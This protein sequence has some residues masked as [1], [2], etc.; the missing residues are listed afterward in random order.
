MINFFKSKDFYLISVLYFIANILFLSNYDG[1]YWDDWI[2]YNQDQ[3]T[4]KILFA[5]IQHGI[6]GDFFLYLNHLGNGIF[7]FR[8]FTFLANF[9]M[10]ILVYLILSN[11]RELDRQSIFFIT[12]L[13][14]VAPLNSAKTS[15]AVA[16]FLFP[17]LL[18]YF[19]FYL[20]TVY[21]KHRYLLLRLLILALFLASCSTNS[22]LVFYFSI[23]FYLYYNQFGTDSTNIYAKIK[24]LGKHYWDFILIP[25]VY[26]IY[27]SLYLK[28]YGLY[29]GYNGISL[30]HLPKAFVIFF[31]NFDNSFIEVIA[32]SVIT[33]LPIWPIV[34]IIIFI[35]TRKTN[36][37]KQITHLKIFIGLGIA[38]FFLAVFPYAMVEKNAELESWN[39]RFQLLIPIAFAFLLYFSILF[40]EISTQW[41]KKTTIVI[42]WTLV[43]GF[44]GKNISDQYRAQ[45]DMFYTVAIEENIKDSSDFKNH[46]TFV[47][48]NMLS[49]NLLYNRN[50]MYYELNGI[51]KKTF[52]ND[53][54]LAIAYEHY[55]DFN[56]IIKHRIYKQYNFA[57]WKQDE[58]L[59]VILMPNFKIHVN[60]SMYIKMMWYHM[61]DSTHFR[62]MAKQLIIL[63]IDNKLPSK[64]PNE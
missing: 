64:S 6:K 4:L 8:L 57:S 44:I 39:S 54:K 20:F 60:Q 61:I 29:E 56:N 16:P 45:I 13:F 1:L 58:P 49:Q 37:S 10:G 5:Q 55:A 38:L 23:F 40:L 25:F 59:L 2:G 62:A 52:Y 50:L 42:L 15:I 17:V 63:T 19:G 9:I 22:I 43:L 21:L 32:K 47:I 11:I 53:T 26:F 30:T 7:P 34:V 28:P 3:Q 31:Q 18:Y 36:F 46:S 27:K 12:L 35:L 41:N 14:L 51:L 33:L 48:N 24:Y